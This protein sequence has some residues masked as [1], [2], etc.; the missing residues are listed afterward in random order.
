M[1]I[2]I[3]IK[4]IIMIII[5][6]IIIIKAIIKIL[7]KKRKGPRTDELINFLS[8][9]CY[10]HNHPQMFSN[11]SIYITNHLKFSV[12][13]FIYGNGVILHSFLNL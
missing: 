5:I 11:I 7:H 3:M 2:I 13:R 1:L 6:P 12:K 10:Y 8:Y 9:H 4:I